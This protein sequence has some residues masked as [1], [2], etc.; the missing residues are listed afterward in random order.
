MG[1]MDSATR[2]P[3]G[4][5]RWTLRVLGAAY[6]VQLAIIGAANLWPPVDVQDG[7]WRYVI[8]RGSCESRLHDL[9]PALGLIP[10]ITGEPSTLT[11]TNLVTGEVLVTQGDLVQDFVSDYPAL[12]GVS[13]F[14]RLHDS[15]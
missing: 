14:R 3:A 8:V 11:R 10:Q 9:I 5:W 12:K 15:R 4:R 7:E 13:Y 6:S 2:R 1:R